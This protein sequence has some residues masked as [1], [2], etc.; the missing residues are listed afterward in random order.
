LFGYLPSD[1]EPVPLCPVDVGA[2]LG[3]FFRLAALR[4][5][6][7][8]ANRKHRKGLAGEWGFGFIVGVRGSRKERGLKTE[9][10]QIA[11]RRFKDSTP[12]LKETI[13]EH[14]AGEP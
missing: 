1:L 12:F 7:R 13:P 9:D 3:Y 5:I 8:L 6:Q 10:R 11:E 2:P 14:R 4:D